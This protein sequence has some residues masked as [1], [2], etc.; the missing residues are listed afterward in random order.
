MCLLMAAALGTLC[1]VAWREATM[2]R[3]LSSFGVLVALLLAALSLPVLHGPPLVPV[4]AAVSLLSAWMIGAG[5]CVDRKSTRLNSSHH[6][7]SRMPSSA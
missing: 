3:W 2:P 7:L 6:R 5:V 4:A 1:V